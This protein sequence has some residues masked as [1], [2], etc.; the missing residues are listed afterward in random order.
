MNAGKGSLFAPLKRGEPD[1]AEQRC[2]DPGNRHAAAQPAHG[3]LIMKHDL[4]AESDITRGTMEG[5][6]KAGDITF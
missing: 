3:V 6:I 2:C 5:D 1:H 4:D